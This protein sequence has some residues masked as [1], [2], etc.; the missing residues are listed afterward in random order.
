[1]NKKSEVNG[2]CMIKSL[3]PNAP[4]PWQNPSMFDRTHCYSCI[5]C[6]L[7]SPVQTRNLLLLL[8]RLLGD[9]PAT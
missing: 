8:S 7:M 3:D 1:M 4:H 2:K 9:V 6:R 5:F